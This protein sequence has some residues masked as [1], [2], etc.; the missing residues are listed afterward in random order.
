MSRNICILLVAALF[1]FAQGSELQRF[2]LNQGR[3]NLRSLAT[4]DSTEKVTLDQ[5]SEN[6]GVFVNLG[7]EYLSNNSLTL[8][9]QTDMAV[10][11]YSNVTAFC[12]NCNEFLYYN[13]STS[14]NSCNADTTVEQTFLSPYYYFTKANPVNHSVSIGNTTTPSWKLATNASLFQSYYKSYNYY[15][16]SYGSSRDYY[17]NHSTY[18]LLGLGVGG[19]AASN[20]RGDHPLFS[21]SLNSTGYGSLIFGKDSTLYDSS[22]TPVTLTA[23]TNW[24]MVTKNLTFGNYSGSSFSSNLIFDLQ[25]PGISIPQKYWDG[26]DGFYKNFKKYN[27]SSTYYTEDGYYTIYGNLTKTDLP[28]LV[29]GLENGKTVTLPPAAYTRKS[30]RYNNTLIILVGYIPA[31]TN[32]SDPEN[33]KVDYTILGWPVL[34]QFYS[35]F[36]QKTGSEPTI[37]LYPAKASG[38]SSDDSSTGTPTSLGTRVIQLAVVIVLLAVVYTC[39]KNRAA[40]KLQNDLGEQ[41]NRKASAF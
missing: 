12:R 26:D 17:K 15:Y 6:F 1:V 13:C 20:F 4:T 19:G 7:E 28:N 30:T 39:F 21:V 27:L 14:N 38:S 36:E 37:T 22:K 29:I 33:N 25:H 5:Y 2:A 35:I 18:G 9:N 11:L 10:L 8:K 24:T 41:L 16:T 31:V 32:N 23:D 3:V 40:A 34:S